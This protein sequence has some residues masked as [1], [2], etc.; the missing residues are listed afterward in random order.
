MFK[1]NFYRYS[2]GV[3]ITV[4]A[5]IL[6]SLWFGENAKTHVKNVAE[7]W[8]IENQTA[9]ESAYAISRIHSSFGYGGFI[10]NFKNFV[11]R[12]DMSRVSLIEANLSETEA[13]ISKFEQHANSAQQQ[14]AISKFRDVFENYQA[15]YQL[16]KQLVAAGKEATEIDAQVRVDDR[17]ALEALDYLSQSTLKRSHTA[18]IETDKRISRTLAFMGQAWVLVPMLVLVGGII[19]FMLYRLNKSN[20]ATRRASQYA[21]D[22]LKATPDALIVVNQAG[23][24]VTANIEAQSLFGYSLGELVQLPM[25]ALVPK[26]FRDSH[27]HYLN[28]AF[29][30]ASPQPIKDRAELTALTHD[31]EEIPVEISLSY[32]LRE[33]ETLAIAAVRDIRLRKQAEQR[34]QLASKALD[35]ASEGVLITDADTK[36][37]D[38]NAAL[39]QL[40]GYSRDEL[41]GRRPSIF[42]SGRHDDKFYD[43][44]WQHLNDNGYWKGEVWDRRKDGEMAPNLVSISRVTETD[45]E[46]SNYV[47][48]FSDITLI[49][50]KEQRLEQL[51]HFDQLT[52]LAN[53]LLFH[54]RLQAAMHRARRQQGKCAVMYIDLDGFK[55]VND[56]LGHEAGD[57]VLSKIGEHLKQTVREDDTAAR[58]GGDEFAVILNEVATK[59]EIDALAQRVITQ[60]TFEKNAGKRSLPI[61]TSIGIAVYPQHGE[62]AEQLIRCADKALYHCK[63]H[64]KHCFTHFRDDMASERNQAQQANKA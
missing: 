25:A 30:R 50:E 2:L 22:L 58:L 53:R 36:I 19:I 20:E 48:V 31:N 63:R 15:Q 1:S 3:A 16:A 14:T 34:L 26:R 32:T 62:T 18:N 37:I 57:E 60:L 12:R 13:A 6:A 51:A 59:E 35:E 47:A 9:A 5:A 49:K 40:T 45:G 17:P 41:L 23:E 4:F 54:D 11:L 38:M 56:A 64:G 42:A 29:L 55:Q 61:S 52:G 33:D 24:I 27:A 21:D 10:H 39:C 43:Q 46:V 44:M 8:R 7:H 28:Q